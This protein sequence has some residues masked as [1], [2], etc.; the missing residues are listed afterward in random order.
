M[1][2]C[3][4]SCCQEQFLV[5][6]ILL[7]KHPAWYQSWNHLQCLFCK[8]IN[9]HSDLTFT[10]TMLFIDFLGKKHDSFTEI[11]FTLTLLYSSF[12]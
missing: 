3:V 4:K 6:T 12:V 5:W 8:Q 9:T 11:I 10:K 7:C 2:G 1:S